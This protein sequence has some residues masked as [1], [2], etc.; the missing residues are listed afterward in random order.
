MA[1]SDEDLKKLAVQM[2]NEMGRP[3]TEEEMVDF[4]F[5]SDEERKA[6]LHGQR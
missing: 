6:I 2:A 3:P 4:I 5:G 1:H